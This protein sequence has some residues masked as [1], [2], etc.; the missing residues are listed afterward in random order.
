M[1][2]VTVVMATYNWATVLPYSIASVLEQTFRDFE[3]L[4]VGDGCTDESA[5]VVGHI[6]D[7]RVRWYNLQ[8]NHGHQ[9]AANNWGTACASGDVIAYLGHDD[10]WLPRHLE[11]LVGALDRGAP[12]AHATTLLVKPGEK[13]TGRPGHRWRY[14]PGVW[15]PPTSLAHVRALGLE[16]GGWLPPWETGKMDP[17]GDLCRRMSLVGGPPQWVSRLT[18]IK[19]PASRRRNVYR[20]RPHHEQEAWLRRIRRHAD[21]EAA[22]TRKYWGSTDFSMRRII[23]GIQSTIAVRTRLRRLGLLPAGRKADPPRTAP[24]SRTAEERRLAY[25]AFKGLD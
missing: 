3:L 5:D 13:P 19:F 11:I 15:I 9:Y 7:P 6:A 17:E 1:P 23:N 20:D 21:P 4:V 8:T 24:T 10:L 18:S 14:V 22:F 25:R 16:V 12:V 2:R